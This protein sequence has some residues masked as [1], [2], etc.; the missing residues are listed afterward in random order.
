MEKYL[1]RFYDV[2]DKIGK[3]NFILII[4]IFVAILSTG[5]YQTFSLYTESE[6]LSILNDIKTYSFILKN[7]GEEN[8]V[9]VAANSS[10]NIDITVSN[11]SES[12]LK[13][14]LY[15]STT[16]SMNDINIGYL[17]NNI[18]NKFSLW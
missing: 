13:Y 1:N 4:F 15:Y 9:V 5:F 14:A 7:N 12:N 3:H 10:K 16:A 2:I 11:E 8:S 6:G 17:E 18:E